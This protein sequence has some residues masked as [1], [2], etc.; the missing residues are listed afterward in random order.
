MKK[1]TRKINNNDQPIGLLRSIPDFLPPPEKLVAPERTT[2]VTLA[3]DQ[4]SLQF[5]KKQAAKRGT[6][7]QRMIREVI[8]GYVAHYS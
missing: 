1:K 8:K 2:K 7:Y 4:T 3:L 6:K 5:F